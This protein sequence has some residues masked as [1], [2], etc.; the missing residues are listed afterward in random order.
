[1]MWIYVAV[2]VALFVALT[3]FIV[4]ALICSLQ[5][6]QTL[7][8]IP[9]AGLALADLLVGLFWVPLATAS[10]YHPENKGLCRAALSFEI[11]TM[12]ASL[13]N[14][15]AVSTERWIAIF[16]PLHYHQIASKTAVISFI[17][18][19]WVLSF[20]ML[21]A[22]LLADKHKED[23]NECDIVK[24]IDIWLL[25]VILIIFY[26]VCGIMII[27]QLRVYVIVRKQLRKIRP[28][29][30]PGNVTNGLIA[31]TSFIIEKSFHIDESSENDKNNIE[32]HR[33]LTSIA[34]QSTDFEE[35]EEEVDVLCKAHDQKVRKKAKRWNKNENKDKSPRNASTLSKQLRKL[36]LKK[37]TSE[38]NGSEHNCNHDDE[39]GGMSF[40][41]K[42][43]LGLDTLHPTIK[44]CIEKRTST[45]KGFTTMRT[46]SWSNSMIPDSNHGHDIED[47]VEMYNPA[48]LD[49]ESR[50]SGTRHINEIFCIENRN[51]KRNR[52]KLHAQFEHKHVNQKHKLRKVPN[53]KQAYC[54][55][56]KDNTNTNI[57]K[58]QKGT[59]A[60]TSLSS[61]AKIFSV[62]KTQKKLEFARAA[63]TN[64]VCL[65][66]VLMWAP[67]STVDLLTGLGYCDSCS[68]AHSV[69]AVLAW[70]NSGINALIYAWRMQEFREALRNIMF[71]KKNRSRAKNF[72]FA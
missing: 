57:D 55:H 64:I 71:G 12:H 9:L 63:A 67:K 48:K 72:G 70:A 26:L 3:N 44:I 34:G 66:F 18:V 30:K 6:L 16:K 13:F 8:N 58:R 27:M 40:N 61:F 69:S 43:E 51:A 5:R 60:K 42:A 35:E 7:R 2:L 49:E 1:M 4:L 25:Y 59:S 31:A 41:S 20:A 15:I 29:V 10:S 14:L 46:T 68:L 39:V 56:G 28:M 65:C 54:S 23:V 38:S 33:A 45:K 11:L 24:Y 62:M 36:Y 19:S 37:G 52:V 22:F 53:R 21:V 32:D 17:A 50:T 47:E